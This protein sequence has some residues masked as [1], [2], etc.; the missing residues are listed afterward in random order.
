METREEMA[1][2]TTTEK[3][4]DLGCPCPSS[5]PT[6]TLPNPNHTKIKYLRKLKKNMFFLRMNTTLHTV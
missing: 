3:A 2:T 5:F 6:L 4:A 1:T